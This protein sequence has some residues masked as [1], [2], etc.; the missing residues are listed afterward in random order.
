MADERLHFVRTANLSQLQNQLLVCSNCECVHGEL[1]E[2][3]L[4]IL[5]HSFSELTR[6]TMG[7]VP[8]IVN[9]YL[10]KND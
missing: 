7:M 6:C 8:C 2:N 1:Y 4:V 9:A 5:P 10:H 3:L